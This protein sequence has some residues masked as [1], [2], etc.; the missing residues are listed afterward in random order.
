MNFS[1]SK[2]AGALAFVASLLLISLTACSPGTPVDDVAVA[3]M[4]LGE[5]QATSYLP[6]N[7]DKPGTPVTIQNYLVPG[8]FTLVQF[9]SPYD[10]I[11]PG[12]EAQ[13][14]RLT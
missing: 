4:P 11:S 9:F 5:M 14:I 8:K 13:L 12:L 7:P 2:N 1:L 10:G 6:L 3:K